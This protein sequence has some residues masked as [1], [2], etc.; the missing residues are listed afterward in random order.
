[1]SEFLKAYGLDD[2]KETARA[3]LFPFCLK[4]S[5][6]VLQNGG[7]EALRT[8]HRSADLCPKLGASMRRNVDEIAGDD[9]DASP[10]GA[11]C[12]P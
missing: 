10:G 9:V 8:I 11:C 12:F 2:I 7:A 3:D 4:K 5:F 1:M 6:S